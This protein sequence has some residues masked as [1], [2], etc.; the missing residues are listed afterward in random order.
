MFF[1]VVFIIV[2]DIC[3]NWGYMAVP[4]NANIWFGF[5]LYIQLSLS[6]I[7]CFTALFR[8]VYTLTFMIPRSLITFVDVATISCY[9]NFGFLWYNSFRHEIVKDIIRINEPPVIV[10]RFIFFIFILIDYNVI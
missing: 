2:D 1:L 4:C 8:V 6:P 3:L 9:V 10:I 7:T 5:R